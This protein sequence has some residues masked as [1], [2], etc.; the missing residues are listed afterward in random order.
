MS[1]VETL[2]NKVSNLTRL[3]QQFID[4]S[5][6]YPELEDNNGIENDMLIAVYSPSKNKLVKFPYT[7]PDLSGYQSISQKDEID[8]YA[9]LDENSLINLNFVPQL[10]IDRIDLLKEVF[11]V[12]GVDSDGY[13]ITLEGQQNGTSLIIDDSEEDIIFNTPNRALFNG[14]AEFNSSSLFNVGLES[15]NPIIVNRTPSFVSNT[16]NTSIFLKEDSTIT[17]TSIPFWVDS[18]RNNATST[19]AFY[20][21]MIRADYKGSDPIKE[22]FSSYLIGRHSGSGYVESMG[23]LI[24]LGSHRSQGNVGTLFGVEG[25]ALVDD[26]G[27]DGEIDT[28]LNRLSAKL[29]NSGLVVNDIFAS[30][31]TLEL[32][33][34]EVGNR[35]YVLELDCKQPTTPEDLALLNVDGDFAYIGCDDTGLNFTPAG[36]AY[37]LKSEVTLPSKLSGRLFIDVPLSEIVSGHGKTAINKEYLESLGL[38]TNQD[39]RVE[40]YDNFN[41]VTSATLNSD[42]PADP[43][44]TILVNT[45]SSKQELYVRHSSTQWFKYVGVAI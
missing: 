41:N 24:A 5:K 33:K 9:G 25:I 1:S 42:R 45:N 40:V 16:L 10:P 31:A 12:E 39:A 17:G 43:V 38:Q 20:G 21:G 37:F 2:T 22:V 32:I 4:N 34:G 3:F 29:N 23:A 35:A 26:Y 19:D 13:K 44:G 14:V 27:G 36:D 28:V 6:T 11:K 7:V 30:S 15:K 18:I 8:G